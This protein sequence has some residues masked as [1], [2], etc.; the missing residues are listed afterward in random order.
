M[1]IA[2]AY[3]HTHNLI[4]IYIH[5]YNI[6]YPGDIRLSF[7]PSQTIILVGIST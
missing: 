4:Y 3:T 1:Y 5:T 6:V 7:P 2:R